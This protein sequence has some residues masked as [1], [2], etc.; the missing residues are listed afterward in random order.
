MIIGIGTDLLDTRRIEKII[1][2]HPIR[3]LDKYFT[4]AEIE[5]YHERKKAG[6]HILYLTS[7]F[8]AKEAVS[9]ALGTGFQ[10][11]LSMK[12]IEIGNDDKGKPYVVL[13]DEAYRILEK[14]TPDGI[15]SHL[16]I[17]LTDE[18]PYAQVFVVIE[19]IS[20]QLAEN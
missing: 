18:V 6:T 13:H 1:G 19:A 8:A 16:H 7:R 12:D 9:K 11:G 5:K 3:F 4:A 20:G 10:G 15:E 14:L 2:V 17:T